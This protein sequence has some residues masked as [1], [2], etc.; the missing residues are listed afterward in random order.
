M[1]RPVDTPTPQPEPTRRS[2]SPS[3]SGSDRAFASL[4]AAA[5]SREGGASPRASTARAA[6]ATRAGAAVSTSSP[7]SSSVTGGSTAAEQTGA[8]TAP[9]G[10]DTPTAAKPADT[11]AAAKPA[12]PKRDARVPEGE[13]WRPVSGTK[14]YAEIT[15]GERTGRYVNLSGNARDGMAFAIEF[16]DG[17]RFHVYGA[18]DEVE[19]PAAAGAPAGSRRAGVTPPTGETWARVKGHDDYADILSGPRN[20]HYVNLAGNAREGRDFLIVRRDGNTYHVYG[21]GEDKQSVRVSSRDAS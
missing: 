15:A 16:R 4:H 1:I 20:G 10:A 14:D 18:G 6:S 5:L 13:N 12:A 8:T 2:T 11:P 19:V 3:K 21:S 17:K 9:T 7:R